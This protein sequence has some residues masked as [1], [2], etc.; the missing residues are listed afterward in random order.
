[1]IEV[2]SEECYCIIRESESLDLNAYICPSGYPTIGWGHTKGVK[3]GD[4]ITLERA[5][6]FLKEDVSITEKDLSRLLKKRNITWLDQAQF[7][8]LVS[9]DFNCR[10]GSDYLAINIAPTLFHRLQQKRAWGAA[11]QMLTIRRGAG[12]VLGGLVKRRVHEVQLFRRNMAA[13]V[14]CPRCGATSNQTENG[15]PDC[16]LCSECHLGFWIPAIG[17]KCETKPDIQLATS[18]T[19]VALHAMRV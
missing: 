18:L 17:W 5:K 19:D 12:R 6:E 2:A 4:T 13:P 3:M 14:D 11:F 10:G 7:D 8:A 16:F 15:F 9:L 1:M